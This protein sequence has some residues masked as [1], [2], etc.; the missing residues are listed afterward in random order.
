[1]YP[2]GAAPLTQN[3]LAIYRKVPTAPLITQ[4]LD[5]MGKVSK[6]TYQPITD[7][8]AY[9]KSMV[10]SD[11]TYPKSCSVRGKWVVTFSST[12]NG[13]TS[14]P[15]LTPDA[16]AGA[17]YTNLEYHYKGAVTDLRGEGFLGF[18]S[19]SVVNRDTSKTWDISYDLETVA[20][21][22][23]LH[24]LAGLP[25]LQSTT[26]TI[27]NGTTGAN[28]R[29]VWDVAN[30]TEFSDASVVAVRFG[31]H[32]TTV[33][34][35]IGGAF[36]GIFHTSG[37][38]Q[39]LGYFNE[40]MRS[41]STYLTQAMD[42]SEA[43]K[44]VYERV[45]HSKPDLTN[46]LLDQPDPT[47]EF[48]LTE[49]SL[50]GG[51]VKIRNYFLVPEVQAG[52]RPTGAIFQIRRLATDPLAKRNTTYFR[53]EEGFVTKVLVEGTQ[54]RT[55]TVT[56]DTSGMFP[57]AIARE[58]LDTTLVYHPQYGILALEIDPN[59][60][61]T[62]QS[63]DGFLRTK[64]AATDRGDGASTTYRF[65]PGLL[66]P[67]HLA[68][69]P[70]QIETKL[71]GGGGIR[72]TL[73][74]LGRTVVDSSLQSEGTAESWQDTFKEYYPEGGLRTFSK[75]SGPGTSPKMTYVY[76]NAQRLTSV[77]DFL[78]SETTQSYSGRTV[79]T[80][81]PGGRVTIATLDH[82]GRTA[83]TT[84]GGITTTLGYEA[85]GLLKTM[86]VG[87][88]NQ[89]TNE[90]DNVGRRTG[91]TALNQGRITFKYNENDELIWSNDANNTTMEL[92]RDELGR[93]KERRNLTTGEKATYTWDAEDTGKGRLYSAT[94]FDGTTTTNTYDQ[95]G[96]LESE[97]TK[98][99]ATAASGFVSSYG[100]QQGRLTSVT[101]P[102]VNGSAFAVGYEYDQISGELK[103]A[104]QQIG[105]Q[106]PETS[107]PL[108]QIQSRSKEG[109]ATA[110]TLG[111][112]M[113]TYTTRDENLQ[114]SKILS[115]QGAYV[116]GLINTLLP[117]LQ[118]LQYTH[119][120]DGNVET[121]RDALLQK[122]ETFTYDDAGRIKTWEIG[123]GPKATYAYPPATNELEGRTS[124][125]GL[126][127]PTMSLVP[128]G[129][130]STT[131]TAIQTAT[132]GSASVG[133]TYDLVGNQKSGDGRTTINYTSFNL[134]K[135]MTLA[136]GS[137][138]FRY[139]AFDQRAAKTVTRG[140]AG[141]TTEYHA[142]L[143]ERRVNSNNQVTH[144]LHIVAERHIADVVW[145]DGGSP[146]VL[147]LHR[148]ALGSLETISAQDGTFRERRKFDPFGRRVD[149]I[150][151]TS[152]AGPLVEAPHEG[153]TG[154]EED[155]E[156][157]LINMRGR[158]YDPKTSRFLSTD[159]LVASPFSGGVPTR[160]GYVGND[161]LNATDPSGFAGQDKDEDKSIFD[162][163]IFK[164]SGFFNCVAGWFDPA[165]LRNRVGDLFNDHSQPNPQPSNPGV[166]AAQAA[167]KAP[168]G[169]SMDPS[170]DA[171]G[172]A[173]GAS[174][175]APIWSDQRAIY[176][177]LG[178]NGTWTNTVPGLLAGSGG[179]A[180]LAAGAWLGV[181][182]AI[183][184][185]GALA[186]RALT[187]A[188]LGLSR[189]TLRELAGTVTNAGS[190][191]IL[192]VEN[193]A[194]KIPTGEIRGALQKILGQA[195]AEGV[196]TL[197]IEGRFAN[198]ALQ[199]L[200]TNLAE[201]LGGRVSS[202]GGMDLLTFILGK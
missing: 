28:K 104:Y 86:T 157:G 51:D 12:D 8:A 91:V 52:N 124:S 36:R 126:G 167:P 98:S 46:W 111:P 15:N 184:T 34:E 173:Q 31:A 156:L 70:P 143:Y 101:Y 18:R 188:D 50:I 43:L 77:T 61:A 102:A 148:D 132:F 30:S 138:S 88:V 99:S 9:T 142:D 128:F 17:G 44:D 69:N 172:G 182:W 105:N 38:A 14:A 199:R 120:P 2:V 114:T 13:T 162:G 74:R 197:Q 165:G 109:L 68:D 193:I 190:T 170:V 107:P 84:K 178:E 140:G 117:K 174:T 75:G 179:V 161:P 200:V 37:Y 4:I 164:C 136:D 125:G 32:E 108:W 93:I 65:L 60:V 139:D 16:P 116:P 76:D 73:D 63:Y 25:I 45:T 106:L 154:H 24:V 196:R 122:T 192:R 160:Y 146:E 153:F 57:Q 149:P 23:S 22:N 85:F 181:P 83:S 10:P 118:Q 198:E 5:G 168:S 137:A 158:I 59:G 202:S 127:L 53:N 115:F 82:G 11:C 123:A 48:S 159:P 87:G 67:A 27:T 145:P 94:S 186:T 71:L 189:A 47:E 96:D 6:I 64:S 39:Y 21:K 163:T 175:G 131:P 79:T 180:V 177:G 55:T 119:K 185:G 100:R 1:V 155:P 90:Y 66:D 112:S 3:Q 40:A 113:Q 151:L 194:G 7:S 20:T 62:S 29:T 41:E 150:D 201:R 72:R 176:G 133:Y 26:D 147:Y 56:P 81:E 103:R 58:G 92:I 121:R 195:G 95:F 19:R 169:N 80:T 78:N 166:P 187:A 144:I 35:F 191:R 89:L 33:S 42:G 129:T 171:S 135:D 141:G 110:E 183:E 130:G 152:D 134:P 49:T 97:E 54:T